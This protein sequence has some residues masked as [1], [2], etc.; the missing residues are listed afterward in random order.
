MEATIDADALET[1]AKDAEEAGRP[2]EA[3][4]IRAEA[5]L[6]VYKAVKNFITNEMKLD[7][8][9]LVKMVIERADKLISDYV[10]T[11]M[12]HGWL[13]AT[14]HRVVQEQVK[15]HLE[16]KIKVTVT[17]TVAKIDISVSEK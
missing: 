7:K 2:E 14:V 5:K 3:K 4:V 11:Q 8:A 13:N 17:N 10:N 9:V 1:I 15:K 12:Q 6:S 16:E